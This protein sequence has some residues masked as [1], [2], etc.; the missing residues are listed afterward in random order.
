MYINI[1]IYIYMESFGTIL[2]YIDNR[3]QVYSCNH[4]HMPNHIDNLDH[5]DIETKIY[6]GI[7]YQCVELVRRWLIE[8]YNL[9]FPSINNAYEIFNLEY[10]YRINS[11][12][13]LIRW[14]SITNGNYI[15]PDIGAIL[16]WNNNGDFKYTGHVAIITNI[17]D[18]IVYI[19]EQNYENKKWNKGCNWSRQLLLTFT[20]GNYIIHDKNGTIMGWKIIYL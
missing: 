12:T 16:V 2:G 19:A 6:Y 1:Y 4:N 10:L 11:I 7:K 17:I 9:T 14:I 5:T 13:K 20:N 3:I 8:K 18:N 15:K